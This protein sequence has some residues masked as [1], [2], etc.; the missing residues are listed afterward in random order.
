M[1]N[2]DAI[3]ESITEPV[4]P[5]PI[6][7]A[8]PA[9]ADTL[10]ARRIDTPQAPD[11]V[12]EESDEIPLSEL[13]FKRFVEPKYPRGNAIAR[14]SGWVEVRFRVNQDGTVDDIQV[15]NSEPAGLFDSSATRAVSRWRFKPRHVNGVPTATYTAVRLRFDGSR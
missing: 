3:T 7:E 9:V 8:D 13:E 12:P 5:A 2:P 6:T 14:K 11:A 15:V 4:E 10:A 1:P